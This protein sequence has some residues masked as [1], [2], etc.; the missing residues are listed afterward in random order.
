MS[1]SLFFS[2]KRKR[3]STSDYN[4]SETIRCLALP[5]FA[6]QK[7]SALSE[8]HSYEELLE[9]DFNHTLEPSRSRTRRKG[10]RDLDC[11]MSPLSQECSFDIKSK[12]LLQLS[13]RKQH[14]EIRVRSNVEM[15]Q[16]D[17]ISR[18][19][20][21][22]SEDDTEHF[23][24]LSSKKEEQNPAWLLDEVNNFSKSC[25][26]FDDDCRNTRTI[27]A[28]RILSFGAIGGKLNHS[29]EKTQFNKC[30]SP[31]FHLADF[32]TPVHHVGSPSVFDNIDYSIGND[33]SIDISPKKSVSIQNDCD[34]MNHS[35][36]NNNA[37]SSFENRSPSGVHYVSD[38]SN[39]HLKVHKSRRK[40]GLV[41]FTSLLDLPSNISHLL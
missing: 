33:D 18:L 34:S 25:D 9:E 20:S 6:D 40:K 38:L 14:E 37:S 8:K 11:A 15:E 24:N 10:L 19:L 17:N 21:T 3:L 29:T 27:A 13:N 26:I 2:P 28:N 4:E 35:N 22:S 41:I 7:L 23:R 16:D 39:N 36:D 32:G 1:D 31:D 12:N 30:Y 5:S